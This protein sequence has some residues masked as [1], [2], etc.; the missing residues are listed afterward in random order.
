MSDEGGG[1]PND[2]RETQLF[3]LQ[4]IKKNL[5]FKDIYASICKNVKNWYVHLER[6][7][8][9]VGSMPKRTCPLTT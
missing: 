3:V 1:R 2:R 7:R 4:K 6:G 9:V 5:R 8:E